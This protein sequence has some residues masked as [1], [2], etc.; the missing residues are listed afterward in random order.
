M[1]VEYGL[2]GDILYLGTMTLCPEQEAKEFDYGVVV[3]LNPQSG[4]IENLDI[5]CFSARVPSGGTLQLPILAK[6]HLSER[7]IQGRKF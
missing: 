2:Y 1:L 7:M 5:L 6:F 3:R 4:E